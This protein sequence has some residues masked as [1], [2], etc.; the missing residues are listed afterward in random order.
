MVKLYIA[1]HFAHRKL[2]RR[3]E[4]KLESKYNLDL[5]NP[6]YDTEQR[7]DIIELDKMKEGSKEQVEYF[8]IRDT[9]AL[10][11]RDLTKI[12]KSDGLL[13]YIKSKSLGTPMEIFFAA[14]IL[15]IPVYVITHNYQYH[16]WI[17]KFATHIF[18]NRRAFEKFVKKNYGVKQ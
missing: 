7:N 10:V 15:Q 4:L 6:F 13:A 2:I 16:P 12:R 17:K 14:R 18:P 3:W 8:K 5:D 11:D 9:E 1:H